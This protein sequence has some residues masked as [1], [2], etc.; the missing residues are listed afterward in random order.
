[1]GKDFEARREQGDMLRLCFPSVFTFSLAL[2][3]FSSCLSRRLSWNST[4]SMEY[5]SAT[6][7]HAKVGRVLDASKQS[8]WICRIQ[9]RRSQFVHA[10]CCRVVT[11]LNSW[12]TTCRSQFLL[13][14]QVLEHW[15]LHADLVWQHARAGLSSWLKFQTSSAVGHVWCST[16]SIP[17]EWPDFHGKIMSCI[18]RLHQLVRATHEMLRPANCTCGEVVIQNNT[19]PMWQKKLVHSAVLDSLDSSYCT[20]PLLHLFLVT[21][22][23]YATP[24]LW[25]LTARLCS[26]TV[27]VKPLSKREYDALLQ[28]T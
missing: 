25:I 28:K 11:R 27:E 26:L 2:S 10:C 20:V 13:G 12:G 8:N 19:K 9:E 23:Q 7:S 17:S 15:Q 1:M 21:L 3:I 24:L 14:M 18:S 22:L 4:N 6:M 16:L 5:H